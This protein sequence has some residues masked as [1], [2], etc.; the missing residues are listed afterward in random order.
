MALAD[1]LLPLL[2]LSADEEHGGVPFDWASLDPP[3]A[4]ALAFL[5]TLRCD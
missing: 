1:W 4:P 2:L 5:P 3:A